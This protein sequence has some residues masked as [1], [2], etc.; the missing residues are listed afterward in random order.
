MKAATSLGQQSSS[1]PGKSRLSA[2]AA[3]SATGPLPV[4]NACASATS[5][6]LD[7][8]R[9]F[10][11]KYL[12]RRRRYQERGARQPEEHALRR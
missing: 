12:S 4:K 1:G 5:E 8:V 6:N 7:T 2:A 10:A 3:V 11:T 9:I